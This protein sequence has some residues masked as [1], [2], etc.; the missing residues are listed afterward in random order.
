MLAK[1]LSESGINNSEVG[2]SL[3]E[4][5]YPDIDTIKLSRVSN[6]FEHLWTRYL[7]SSFYPQSSDIIFKSLVISAMYKSGLSPLYFQASFYPFPNIDFDCSSYSKLFGPI[8]LSFAMSFKSADQTLALKSTVLKQVHPRSKS[9]LI[10]MDARE[11]AV[12]NKKIGVGL[13][14]GLDKVIVANSPAFDELVG[15]LKSY[16]LY[17]PNPVDVLTSTRFIGN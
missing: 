5:L 13:V 7:E 11:A 4:D 8:T 12:V 15:D 6:F 2:L 17:Q 3:F 10:T 9:F 1:T 16:N 14:L